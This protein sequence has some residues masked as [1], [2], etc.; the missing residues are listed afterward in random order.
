MDWLVA[1]NA[2][3]AV[4]I[5]GAFSNI[6]INDAVAEHPNCQSSFVRTFVKGVI[7]NT[8]LLDYYIDKLAAKGISGIKKRTL[9][10]LRMGLYAI[11][12]LDSVPDYAACNEAVGLAKKVSRGSDR[13]VNG[14]LRSYIREKDAIKLENS[15]EKDSDELLS[16]KYSFPLELVRLIRSQYSDETET[17]LAALNTAAPLVL[18]PNR[19][20]GMN[21]EPII[22]EGNVIA[23]DDF[24]EGRYSVQSLSSI[25]AIEHFAPITGSRVLDMCAAPGGKSCAMAEIMG[26]QGEIIACDIYEHRLELIDAQ[27]KRLGID[28]IQTALLDG[29]VH[30][31][32]YDNRFDYV[33]ADVP[34]SGLGVIPSK[35][36]IKLRTDV[37][38]YDELTDIQYS[39]LHNAI[40]Y[41][42]VG[43][44][45]EYSTCTINKNE[46]YELV[47][48]VLDNCNCVQIVENTSILPYNSKVGFYYCILEKINL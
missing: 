34:C 8:M 42:K 32:D 5:D 28:I 15:F 44:R 2:L 6:A 11:T 16:V 24:R 13:F 38:S 9:I 18:R 20:K 19:L 14:L 35:P 45:I 33:L 30:R 22:A 4:Y 31:D 25:E 40:K 7:R 48:R 39:I 36:E 21:P 23:S 29:T 43:G 37:A 41:A 26:N 27:A 10:I 1:F 12:S 47:K 46:N 17:L 3:R